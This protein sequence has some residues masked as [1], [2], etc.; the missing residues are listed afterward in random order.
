MTINR[1][2]LQIILIE[3]LLNTLYL[4]IVLGLISSYVPA[5]LF[6]HSELS[7]EL[8]YY[9]FMAVMIVPLFGWYYLWLP[10]TCVRIWMSSSAKLQGFWQYLYKTYAAALILCVG[11]SLLGLFI[12]LPEVLVLVREA[13][14]FK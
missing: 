7:P 10:Y 8:S 1:T 11:A 4:I 12:N 6:E 13:N 9:I 14:P 3:Q 2:P 5:L